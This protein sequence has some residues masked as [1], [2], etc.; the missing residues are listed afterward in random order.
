MCMRVCVCLVQVVAETPLT[1]TR[2]THAQTSIRLNMFYANTL[3]ERAPRQRGHTSWHS[4]RHQCD[5]RT[6]VRTYERAAQKTRHAK[7]A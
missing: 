6:H 4:S 7:R 1:I 5:E 3:D 2:E